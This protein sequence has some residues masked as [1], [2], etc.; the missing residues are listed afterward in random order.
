[1]AEETPTPSGPVIVPPDRDGDRLDRVLSDL[2]RLTRSR[3]QILIRD[4]RISVAGS[5]VVRPSHPVSAGD[6]IHLDVPPP[7]PSTLVPED[8]PLDVRHEDDHVLV[9]VKPAGLVV[10]P[11]AGVSSG[12]LVNALL[13]RLGPMPGVGGADRPGI[14]HRLDKDTTG[15]MVVAKTEPAYL[16]LVD[17]IK[18]RQVGRRY[19]ALV[20]GEPPGEFE[21]DAPIGRHP[22]DRVRMAVV[23]G[24]RPAITE[25][26]VLAWFDFLSE[27]DL[28]LV[29]GRTHQIRVHLAHRGFPVFGDPVYDGRDRQLQRLSRDG[30]ALARRLLA[31]FPRQALHAW[32][33]AF[34]HPITRKSLRFEAEVPDDLA[35]VRTSLGTGRTPNAGS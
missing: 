31:A 13:H 20:W 17:Q 33:L 10:H 16:G 7:P 2:T 12:T 5:V 23:P 19:R 34:A 30:R 4:G 21:V 22:R 1:M 11:G 24:G 3:L 35:H 8:I 6:V 18:R 29:S 28:S 27:L 32:Q 14:V 26:R 25:A 15:L 9:L